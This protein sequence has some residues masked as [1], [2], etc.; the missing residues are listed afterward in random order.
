M[1]NVGAM[2]V[3]E[4]T[5]ELIDEG[6]D[7]HICE[8]LRGSNNLRQVSRVKICDDEYSREIVIVV[9]R[10]NLGNREHVDVV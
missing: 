8:W 5:K 7:M 10:E 4:A 2:D 3:F 1:E 9:G 6:L